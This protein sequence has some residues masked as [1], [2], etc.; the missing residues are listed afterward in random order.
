MQSKCVLFFDWLLSL[1][2]IEIHRI[3]CLYH[4]FLFTAGLYSTV[5]ICNNLLI[6]SPVDGHL[7]CFKY[8]LLIKLLYVDM[9][10]F[11]LAK[12]LGVE[13]LGHMFKFLT[14]CQKFSKV[15]VPF[16]ILTSRVREF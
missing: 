15:V 16:C 5:W 12:Y 7:G 4:L 9:L 8:L 1:S 11:L 6:H 14:N 13:W 3:C 2:I 10:S